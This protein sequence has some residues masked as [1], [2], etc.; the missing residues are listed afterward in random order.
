MNKKVMVGILVALV[1][2]VGLLGYAL[3]TAMTALEGATNYAVPDKTGL[4]SSP[5]VANHSVGARTIAPAIYY[6]TYE[7]TFGALPRSLRGTKIPVSFTLDDEGHLVITKSIK[8]LIEYFLSLVGE[9][10]VERITDRIREFI[11]QQL[12]EPAESEAIAVLDR[13][14][15][16][17]KALVEVEESL[18]Y[19]IESSGNAA[20][21]A[22]MFRLRRET[23][24]SYLGQEIYD[25][26]FADEDKKAEYTV[27]QMALRADD[28]LSDAEKREKE[29][30]LERLLPPKEQ[31]HKNLERVRN[32][33]NERV[34]EAKARGASENEIFHLRT[35]VYGYEAARRFASADK[36][37]KAWD[38]RF[39]VYREQR[40]LILDAEGMSSTDKDAQIIQLQ[41]T[42]FSVTE[43][44]RIPTL[45]RMAEQQ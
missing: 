15:E 42:L 27:A 34:Q 19:D 5:V 38:L 35:E 11:Q 8:V 10:S 6:D 14:L 16:Y 31:E 36:E 33:L 20:D 3:N 37:S 40:Q 2:V 29:R 7:S 4:T 22:T 30:E 1:L 13:Y 28:S 9:E 25:A 44:L 21:Y 12:E 18:G 41:D 24:I 45:D 32:E 17:K 23:R 26:F 39:S 43:R